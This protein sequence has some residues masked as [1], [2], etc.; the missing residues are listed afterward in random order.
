MIIFWS[1]P[2]DMPGPKFVP[3]GQANVSSFLFENLADEVECICPTALNVVCSFFRLSLRCLNRGKDHTKIY[4]VA[5]RS[6]LGFLRDCPALFFGFFGF[7]VVAHIHGC[8]LHYLLSKPFLGRLV[9]SLYRRVVI[10]VPSSYC[11]DQLRGKLSCV[12]IFDVC[13]P[14]IAPNHCGASYGREFPARRKDVVRFIWNSNIMASKGILEVLDAFCM[15]ASVVSPSSFSLTVLGS[16]L[17]DNEMNQSDLQARLTQYR[18]KSF[19]EFVGRVEPLV[20][21]EYLY[22]SHVVILNSRYSS[23]CQ[24][25]ALVDA[26]INQKLIVSSSTPQLRECLD[27]YPVSFISNP[28]SS[29]SVFKAVSESYRLSGDVSHLLALRDSSVRAREKYDPQSFL[30]SMLSIFSGTTS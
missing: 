15:L 16:V 28:H 13:N 20:A 8:D 24:P 2:V 9:S 23:E 22:S 1:S 29:E 17:S 5:S 3:T 21:Q 4:I 26:M 10:V 27:G 12:G 19:I 18:N 25:L 7:K 11:A 30:T 6:P 14:V